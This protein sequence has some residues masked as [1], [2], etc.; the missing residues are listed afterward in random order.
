MQDKYAGDVGDFSKFALLRVLHQEL[1]GRV[2]PYGSAP[3]SSRRR[4]SRPRKKGNDV[5][6]LPN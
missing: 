2:G 3:R 4:K 5:G 6:A 1:G